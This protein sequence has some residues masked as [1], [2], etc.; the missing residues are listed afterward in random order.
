M[1]SIT[2]YDDNLLFNQPTVTSDTT[3][4]IRIGGDQFAEGGAIPPLF[5]G[6]HAPHPFA[7]MYGGR[8]WNPKRSHLEYIVEFWFNNPTS[9]VGPTAITPST[10]PL[11]DK[12]SSQDTLYP[13]PYPQ[14]ENI[15]VLD[16]NSKNWTPLQSHIEVSANVSDVTGATAGG[17]GSFKTSADHD[18]G[19]IYYD[20]RGRHGFVNHLDTVHVPG[21][22][23]LER[24]NAGAGAVSINISLH[25]NPPSWAH[26]YKIAYAKNTSVQDFVQYSV[27]GAFVQQQSPTQ[28]VL[29]ESLNIYVSLNYLQRHAISYVSDFGAKTPEGGLNLYKF[30]EG[31]K[32]RVISYGTD[33]NR[34]H[35]N[36]YEFDVV[37][38]V[39]LGDDDN[40]LAVTPTEKQKG[41][42]V[43]L[44][45]NVDAFGF[46]ASNAAQDGGFWDQNCVVELRT[47]SKASDLEDKLYYEIGDT[48]SVLRDIEA[49]GAIIHGTDSITLNEGDVWFRPI[50]VNF[51]DIDGGYQDLI[52]PPLE[53]NENAR[54]KSNFKN[55][56]LESATATDLFRGDSVSIGRPNVM[57]SDSSETVREAT[58][59][60]SDPSN[61][62]SKTT[63][64][65]SFNNS[66]ANF[67]DLS[68]KHGGINYMSDHSDS[69]F[70]LQESKTSR[71][72]VNRS[73]LSN[74]SG[75]DNIIASRSVLNEAIYYPGKNG[76][77]NNPSS[78]LDVEQIVFFANKALGKVYKYDRTKGVEVISD[79]D[80]ASLLRNMFKDA[81]D[82][83]GEFAGNTGH[84]RIVG[85]YDPVK[86]E[87][88]VTVLG[89]PNKGTVGAV[90][91]DQPNNGDL[92]GPGGGG[93]PDPGPDTDTDS[94]IDAGMIVYDSNN[95]GIITVDDFIAQLLAAGGVVP[96]TLSDIVSS[97][98]ELSSIASTAEA[99]T[100][101]TALELVQQF[102]AFVDNPGE[103]KYATLADQMTVAEYNS[104]KAK[105]GNSIIHSDID[106]SGNV[107]SADLLEFL[108][109]FGLMLPEGWE[110]SALS[111]STASV[112][113]PP[114]TP[115]ADPA[116][117]TLQSVYCEGTTKWG[118]YADG[119]GGTYNEIIEEN[120]LQCGYIAPFNN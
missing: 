22:S 78:V 7:V 104:L 106:M 86:E 56:Y 15:L 10:L 32:L 2:S 54:P 80:V 29:D 4:N 79:I 46:D 14:D 49:D 26:Y 90:E 27:G 39:D 100:N 38:V 24:S 3:K 12:L 44:K 21:Y 94:D 31:D 75:V 58:I 61:P 51:K 36:N 117:G 13:L 65:S 88:L 66:L 47:P 42:F 96:T 37:G 112:E 35:P 101:A 52:I 70:V 40:L 73:V 114:P 98:T 118:E 68:E 50:A 74:A 48:Y 119:S 110:G 41:Q 99:L 55:Y 63:N 87:Y 19:I 11:I 64:Y 113:P 103:D 102:L 69:V 1:D 111:S 107:S 25:F 53:D 93:D 60:Y 116:A 23:P 71:I 67:K 85:G 89:L 34:I 20:E 17:N 92:T 45:D 120:S 9:P 5:Y 105:V 108:A 33:L 76:C 97:S 72:P 43:I 59:I 62:E 77:D 28:E 82:G 6:E 115:P 83:T 95:D 109:N 8:I 91:V 84:I 81:L 16:A 30:Q 18:F 57:S